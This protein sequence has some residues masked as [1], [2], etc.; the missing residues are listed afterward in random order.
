MRITTERLA[1]GLHVFSGYAN[2]NVLAL[3]TRD[4]VFLVD[5]QSAKR[6][7][8][9]DTALRQVTQ[10]PVKW[11]VNTH[12]HGDHTE[13]NA[14]FRARG[15]EVWAHPRVPVQAAKDT[16]IAALE[17]HRTPLDPAAMP[18]KLVG[19][20]LEMTLGGVRVTVRHYGVAHTDGDLLT[21]LPAYN[22]LHIGDLFEVGAPPFV[23]WW[24]GGSLDGMIKVIDTV[25]T[26]V[27]DSTR[28]VPGH[29]AVSTRADLRRYREML[30][31]VRARV[32]E[33]L[34][35]G[36]ADAVLGASAVAGF[37]GMLG[38]ERRA[39][40]FGGQVILGLRR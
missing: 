22:V 33:G 39:K 31:T 5:A 13:G 20:L 18:T 40:Q 26:E 30:A 25:L 3:E 23:D 7:A 28:I 29:G 36:T 27:N 24:A 17:W 10:A 32:R 12:Y 8:A 16:T 19:D 6:V 37:E 9:L 15:A 14:F 2:G 34:A 4:G 35:A 11:I 21:W 1:P 38:G